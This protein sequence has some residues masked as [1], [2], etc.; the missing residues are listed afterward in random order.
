MDSRGAACGGGRK[1]EVQGDQ[2]REVSL[3]EAPSGLLPSPGPQPREETG[4]TVPKRMLT[5]SPLL[6]RT[7]IRVPSYNQNPCLF[8]LSHSLRRTTI[9]TTPTQHPLGGGLP[10]G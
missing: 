10:M 6:C 2:R 7:S 1:R 8:L 4:T 3:G 5:K 9:S